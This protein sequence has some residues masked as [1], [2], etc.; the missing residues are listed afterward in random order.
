LR[1][2]DIINW[3]SHRQQCYKTS[4]FAMCASTQSDRH[5]VAAGYGTAFA[6][7]LERTAAIAVVVRIISPPL[8]G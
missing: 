7:R 2:I 8:S 6:C 3:N 1:R 5:H 4:D